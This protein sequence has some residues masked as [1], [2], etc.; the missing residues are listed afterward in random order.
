MFWGK[1]PDVF[2]KLLEESKK[3]QEVFGV[4]SGFGGKE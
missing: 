1:L 2:K 4:G 3:L